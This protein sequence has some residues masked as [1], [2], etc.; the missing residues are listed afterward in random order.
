MIRLK[1]LFIGIGLGMIIMGA[2]CFAGV[3]AYLHKQNPKPKHCDQ[4]LHPFEVGDYIRHSEY[5]K[6]MNHGSPIFDSKG[7][8]VEVKKNGKQVVYCDGTNHHTS[9]SYWME[10]VR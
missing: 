5:A 2:S 1:E 9:A 4:C 3:I 8:I 6:K 7:L 10:R